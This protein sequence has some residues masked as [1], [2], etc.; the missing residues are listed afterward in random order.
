MDLMDGIT[1]YII[2]KQEG[3]FPGPKLIQPEIKLSDR[4][5][6]IDEI[7]AELDDDQKPLFAEQLR[8]DDKKYYTP[9][10]VYEEN[11]PKHNR[12][13][14]SDSYGDDDLAISSDNIQSFDRELQEA[15][16]LLSNPDMPD[17]FKSGVFSPY[18][19]EIQEP[20]KLYYENF[21]RFPNSF[22][23]LIQNK[24]LYET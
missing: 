24:Q 21:N 12:S 20:L 13:L 3:E 6:R 7:Y 5:N 16:K 8:Q 19:E 17:I 18:F 23:E 4:I 2:S 1:N 10:F 9:E 15:G 14:F 11:Y 22:Q